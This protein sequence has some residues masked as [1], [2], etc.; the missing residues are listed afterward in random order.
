[1]ILAE[2]VELGSV[3]NEDAAKLVIDQWG[4]LL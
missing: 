1:M 3:N 2:N 4:V